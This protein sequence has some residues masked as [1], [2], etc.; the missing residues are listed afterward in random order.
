VRFSFF[1]AQVAAM[2]AMGALLAHA[3]VHAPLHGR[4]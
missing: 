3:A 4:P 1:L 2:L